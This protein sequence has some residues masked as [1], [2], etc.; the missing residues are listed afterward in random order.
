LPTARRSVGG[1]TCHLLVSGQPYSE[2]FPLRKMEHLHR[3]DSVPSVSLFR[4]DGGG[5]WVGEVTAKNNAELQMDDDDL[6]VL[7]RDY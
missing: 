4:A 6:K 3:C 5:V 2:A 1:V 7:R